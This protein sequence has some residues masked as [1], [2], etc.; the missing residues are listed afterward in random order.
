MATYFKYAER[1]ASSD[2]NWFEIGKNLTDALKKEADVREEK[3]AA[4]DKASREYGEILA[5]APTGDSKDMNEWALKFASDAQQARLLQDRLLKSGQLKLKDY[6]IMRQNLSD[7]TK[8]AFSLSEEYQKEYKEKMER[9]KSSDP[10]TRSQAL[11]EFYMAQAEGFANFKNTNLYINPTNYQVSVGKMYKD[12]DGVYKMSEN[13]NDFFTVNELRNRMKDRFD[14]F[15][16]D[17]SLNQWVGS[18]GKYSEVVNAAG[19]WKVISDPLLRDKLD[20][21]TK[22]SV[23]ELL[24]SMDNEL[25]SYIFANPYNGTSLLTEDIGAIDGKAVDFTF[26]PAEAAKNK[27]L[28]LLK[29]DPN[30]PNGPAVP[31]FS[32]E[33]QDIMLNFMK[34]Q[35]KVKL[36]HTET[37]QQKTQ[38]YQQQWEAEMGQKKKEQE[39][40]FNVWNKI[41]TASSEAEKQA[42]VNTILGMERNKQQ[43]L[44]D[45]DFTTEGEVTFRYKNSDKD[46]TMKFDKNTTLLQWAEQGNEVTGIDNADVVLKR[47]G[48]GD[49]NSTMVGS[50][51]VTNLRASRGGA[52]IDAY[53]QIES[54]VNAGFEEDSPKLV[55]NNLS[56]NFAGSGLLFEGKTNMLTDDVVVVKDTKGVVIGEYPVDEAEQLTQLVNDL[57]NIVGNDFKTKLVGKQG[58]TSTSG[59]KGVMGKYN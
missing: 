3:K 1:N 34:T 55:A 5:N 25:K 46:R 10:A 31:E 23:N 30:N 14:Y 40:A 24:E 54:L 17:K 42:A 16:Y 43:G 20:P 41:F 38:R 33:Q 45:I 35:A 13:P 29:K 21:K 15:D 9:A 56:K 28:V 57:N 58:G 27:N 32:K 4:I 2:V 51:N 39:I 52:P 11:E 18:L 44:I 50:D 12:S 7:G 8:T 59:G 6:T 53:S 48:G 37:Y 22:Q 36:E 49:P 47:S 26:D 19:G